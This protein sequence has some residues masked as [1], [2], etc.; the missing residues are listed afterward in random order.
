MNVKGLNSSK[1]LEK[2]TIETQGKT[3]IY[4]FLG[5]SFGDSSLNFKRATDEA[6]KNGR[7]KGIPNGDILENARIRVESMGF[8]IVG[9]RCLIVEGDLVSSV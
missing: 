3:C 7:I 2:N 4:S 8:I 1:G 5:I 9:R 6:I